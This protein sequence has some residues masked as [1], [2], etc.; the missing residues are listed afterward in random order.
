MLY[1]FFVHIH[2][3]SVKTLNP[4]QNIDIEI[5]G[6]FVDVDLRSIVT[7]LEIE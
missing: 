6:Q 1:N 5:S 4:G 7:V 3:L 2:I